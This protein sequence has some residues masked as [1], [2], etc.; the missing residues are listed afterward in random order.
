MMRPEEQIM[1]Q[2]RDWQLIKAYL[3]AQREQKLGLLVGADSHDASNR[4][5]GALSMIQ[6]LLALE[7]A[8]EQAAQRNR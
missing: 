6:T 4:Y 1:F 5:R 8:A 3:L 7:T 2:G